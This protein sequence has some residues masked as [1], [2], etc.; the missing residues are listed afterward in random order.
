[1]L[2][3][4]QEVIVSDPEDKVIAGAVD[5]VKAVGG[6]IGGL[7][8][9]VE[10]FDHLLERA[11]FFGNSIVVGKTNDL[12]D[13]ERKGFPEFFE[14]FHCGEWIGAVAVSDELKFFRQPCKAP[15][16]H[17]HGEDAGTDAPVVGDLVTDDGTGGGIHDEPD[18]GFDAA[19]FDVG[20]ICGK[21]IPFF[22]RIL[23]NKGLDADGGGPAVVGDLLVGDANVIKIFQ[24]LGSFAQGEAEVD[25]ESQAQGHDMCVVFAEF[26]GGSILRQGI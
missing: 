17:A 6:P 5:V 19:Y 25:M 2:V 1:M 20:F 23:V 14:E 11:V 7:V 22:V 24:G 8:G 10:P 9:T 13:P 26:Q 4:A 21:H 16:S 18:K 3:G 15:E 12:C